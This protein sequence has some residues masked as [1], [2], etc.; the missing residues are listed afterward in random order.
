M[1]TLAFH[2][3]VVIKTVYGRNEYSAF[4]SRMK[5]I[6]LTVKTQLQGRFAIRVISS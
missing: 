3:H 6:K 4:R 1:H 5:A 2:L